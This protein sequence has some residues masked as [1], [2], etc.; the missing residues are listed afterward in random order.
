MCGSVWLISILWQRG[1]QLCPFFFE[2]FHL[3]L[4]D[5]PCN[6][7]CVSVGPGYVFHVII[8]FKFV[9]C[10]RID[11]DFWLYRRPEWNQSKEVHSTTVLDI[12]TLLKEKV[13]LLA[14]PRDGYIQLVA[15]PGL[16]GSSGE[17]CITSLFVP[18]VQCSFW[19]RWWDH[20][21]L[22]RDLH[23]Q[24]W[25]GALVGCKWC[26]IIKS[27]RRISRWCFNCQ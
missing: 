26:F 1:E 15:Y 9:H 27:S 2:A 10:C 24:P 6:V 20:T 13:Y 17:S 14:L 16:T 3:P 5:M 18:A 22:C 12:L 4:P 23:T 7:L 19:W 25:E 11:P 8:N 21:W